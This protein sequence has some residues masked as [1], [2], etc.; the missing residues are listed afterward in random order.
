MLCLSLDCLI[1][2][3]VN[4]QKFADLFCKFS[5]Q[6]VYPTLALWASEQK[7][8]C[9]LAQLK[10]IY[11]SHACQMT[12]WDFCLFEQVQY[13]T[14]L[15][16]FAGHGIW[17][18]ASQRM[19]Q[20]SKKVRM[21]WILESVHNRNVTSVPHGSTTLHNK[22]KFYKHVSYIFLYMHSL[23]GTSD[24]YI[25]QQQTI[26]DTIYMSKCRKVFDCHHVNYR[27]LEV[28][29]GWNQSI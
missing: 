9:I 23:K 25:L 8:L 27:S 21:L 7:V 15:F 13:L 26:V 24:F 18:L 12:C 11:L 10:K 19:L 3:V 17:W 2:N 28:L 1:Y 29:F 16:A 22:L 20:I 6:T 5:W 4:K 14:I